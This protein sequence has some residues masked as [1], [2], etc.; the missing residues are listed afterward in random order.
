MGS[1]AWHLRAIRQ[2]RGWSDYYVEVRVLADEEKALVTGQALGDV[3]FAA[4]LVPVGAGEVTDTQLLE[5][6]MTC[7]P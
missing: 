7:E 1:D 4:L 3:R 5:F 6:A 2:G